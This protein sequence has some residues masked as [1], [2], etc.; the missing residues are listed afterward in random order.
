MLNKSNSEWSAAWDKFLLSSHPD[1]GF[2]QSS[3]WIDLMG[4][5]GWGYQDAFYLDG[6]ES[7]QGGAKMLEKEYQPGKWF[8]YIP[9]GFVLPDNQTEAAAQFQALLGYFN[10]IRCAD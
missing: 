7:I 6:N 2:M 8:Y 10:E 1:A 5:Y 4:E 3:W 9:D